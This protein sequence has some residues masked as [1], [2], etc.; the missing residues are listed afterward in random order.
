[1]Y[2]IK[3]NQ[4][5]PTATRFWP[6]VLCKDSPHHVLID[7]D[8]ECSGNLLRD[9]RAAKPL[10]PSFHLNDDL[11]KLQAGSFWPGFAFFSAG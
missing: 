11:D 1:M 5:G 4:E 10:V 2:P 7:F 3:V 6:V 9:P 8:T